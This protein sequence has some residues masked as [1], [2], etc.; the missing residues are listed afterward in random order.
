MTNFS[1][2]I[3]ITDYLFRHFFPSYTTLQIKWLVS[4]CDA[5]RDLLTL[6][7]FKKR[8]S[9]DGGTL[10]LVKLQA[11]AFSKSIIPPWFFSRFCTN[12]TK[13][14]KASHMMVDAFVKPI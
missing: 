10:L 1:L 2:F 7:Q 13:L 14:C 3:S 4:I 9:N 11:N 12:G 8:K 5:F 6:E